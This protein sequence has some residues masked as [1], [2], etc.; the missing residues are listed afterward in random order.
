M[1]TPPQSTALEYAEDACETRHPGS[2]YVRDFPYEKM[3]VIRDTLR[4]LSKP[5]APVRDDLPSFV[6]EVPPMV[7]AATYKVTMAMLPMDDYERMVAAQQPAEV[8][9]LTEMRRLLKGMIKS[10]TDPIYTLEERAGYNAAV[11]EILAVARKM[12]G[13]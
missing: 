9:L 8:D 1:T 4:A 7:Q 13:E 6:I 2:Y 11:S 3:V 12:R 5:T 10:P